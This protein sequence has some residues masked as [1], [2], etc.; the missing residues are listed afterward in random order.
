LA[1]YA[2]LGITGFMP[3]AGLCRVLRGSLAAGAVG[4]GCGSRPNLILSA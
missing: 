4:R 2:E 3:S 1:S